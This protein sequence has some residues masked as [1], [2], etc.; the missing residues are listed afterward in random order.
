MNQADLVVESILPGAA[1]VQLCPPFF[2]AEI[3]AAEF[4]HGSAILS[5]EPARVNP[6]RDLALFERWKQE[7]RGL[8]VG[9]RCVARRLTTIRNQK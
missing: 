2:D 1:I 6:V 5:L 8:T 9:V 4:A 3:G 7:D